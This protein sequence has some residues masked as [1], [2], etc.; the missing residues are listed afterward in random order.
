MLGSGGSSVSRSRGLH[1]GVEMRVSVAGRGQAIGGGF[2][3]LG[4]AGEL[5]LHFAEGR[6]AVGAD[7]LILQAAAQKAVEFEVRGGVIDFD[8]QRASAETDQARSLDQFARDQLR[9]QLGQVAE[10]F[11]RFRYVTLELL[12]HKRQGH[13]LGRSQSALS[14]A[15]ELVHRVV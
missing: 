3:G 7:E 14:H 10:L 5:D 13:V 1:G 6:A 4:L 11:E 8:V 15:L 2:F 9:P 12:D